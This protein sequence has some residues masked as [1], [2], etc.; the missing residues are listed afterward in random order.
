MAVLPIV[1]A[2][3]CDVSLTGNLA[4]HV[5]KSTQEQECASIKFESSSHVVQALF[6]RVHL[7]D[8]EGQQASEYFGV[9]GESPSITVMYPGF[10][11]FRNT[12]STVLSAVKMVIVNFSKFI[13]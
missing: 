13:V 2:Y 1:G 11:S 7:G 9:T 12:R 6:V 5:L 4:Q 3:N 10:L 8:S